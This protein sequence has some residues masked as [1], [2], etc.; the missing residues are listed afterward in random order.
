MTATALPLFP[1]SKANLAGPAGLAA[2]VFIWVLPFHSLVIALL[3]GAFGVAEPT[4]RSIAA[5]KELLVLLLIGWVM[6][7]SLVGSGPK[8]SVA[9]SDVAIG[10]LVGI[11]AAFA[12]AENSLFRANIPTAAALY[13]FRDIAFF[14]LLYYVGRAM[15]E[16]AQTDRLLRHMF[17]VG[18]IISVVGVVERILVTPE[19][20][21]VLGVAAYVN[22][23][24]GMTAFTV[25]N[26]WG[27]PQNYWSVLG[28]VPVRRAGS[29][30]LHSQGFALPFLLL[31]PAA[32]AW[33]LARRHR[34]APLVRI[35]YSLL[36]VGLLL[37]V[38]RM[39]ILACLVQVA[40]FFV[41]FR[42]PEWTV[43]AAVAAVTVFAIALAI[44]PGLAAFAWDTFTWQTG[45]SE[46]HLKDWAKGLTNFL[47]QPWG[48]GL[49][50]T[51]QV[52]VRFG[53]DPLSADN[54]FL[55]YATQLGVAGL[56]AIVGVLG[57]ILVSAW[58]AFRRCD[59]E[60][61][62]RF[63]AVILL[64]TLG[65][66]INASTSSVFSSTLLAYLYFWLAGAVVTTAQ[67]ARGGAPR[68][69]P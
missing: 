9:A 38:T 60:H 42:R 5:W 2:T 36:W 23:F 62:R 34:L 69:S 47:Q 18:V 8:V 15:P 41:M 57:S 59:D 19:V 40:L 20:L 37:T 30:F 29:V 48:N 67:R 52:A 25:G 12:V 17:A 24:L 13:G 50:T 31:M 6:L 64:A 45:S 4:V 55:M 68:Q 53:I 16:I 28:G 35:A 10:L 66:L 7:R 51:D 3:F 22:D 63:G 65:I 49:G 14:M 1:R 33:A 56:I 43:G 44:V 54:M 32:T 27:L 46:S 61:S 11:A 58:T 39:T 26:E 21:V